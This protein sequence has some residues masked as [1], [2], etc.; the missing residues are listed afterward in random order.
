MRPE[1][2]PNGHY[3]DADKYSS[4]PVCNGGMVIDRTV[5]SGVAGKPE[6]VGFEPD[7]GDNF[8]TVP[9]RPQ[10][11]DDNTISM[12]RLKPKEDGNGAG[13]K[14]PF[15]PKKVIEPVVGWLVCTKG[16][17][18]GDSFILK[19]GKN[20]IGRDASM[21]VV[22]KGE[23]TVSRIRHAILVFEPKENIFLAQPGESRELFYLNDKVVL[24]PAVMKK[25]DKL[26]IGDT[27]LMLI[28]CCD[29]AFKWADVE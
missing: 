10:K 24:T 12:N 20:Y 28:P 27:E 1:T 6:M 16:K 4:C 14:G 2:C 29:E 19:A 11:D 3:Y 25:N 9:L 7:Q 18:M 22:L 23:G 17:N 5:P 15:T 26:S 21:D 8:R 13:V